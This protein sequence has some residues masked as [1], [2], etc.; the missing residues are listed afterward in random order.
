MTLRS[1]GFKSR[2]GYF[3]FY[4]L[5]R[6]LGHLGQLPKKRPQHDLGLIWGWG[7]VCIGS[8]SMVLSSCNGKNS[9]MAH[10]ETRNGWYRVVFQIK[11]ERFAKSLNTKSEKSANVCLAKVN[12]N[13]YR[14]DLGLID[15]PDGTDPLAFFL[16][17][18]GKE[19]TRE[20]VRA[21]IKS[22]TIKRAWQVFQ[23]TLPNDALEQ[24]TLSGMQTH[25]DQ[26]PPPSAIIVTVNGAVFRQTLI[27]SPIVNSGKASNSK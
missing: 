22:V 17:Q 6:S 27:E 9:P 26:P 15:I 19:R 2:L 18:T 1:C 8:V 10:L 4:R 11:G 13:L 24:S 3:G 5:K 7:W 25:V 14:F 23:E 16:G 12:D 20:T 21:E